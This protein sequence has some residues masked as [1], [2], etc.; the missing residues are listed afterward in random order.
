MVAQFA[1]KNQRNWDAEI[2]ALQFAYNTAVHD[3]TGYTP[4]YLN[5]GRELISPI[6]DRE[7]DETAP[8]SGELQQ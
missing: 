5:H 4:A 7:N 6:D 2:E 1:G 3:A 8:P